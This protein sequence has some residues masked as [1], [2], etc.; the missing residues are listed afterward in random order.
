MDKLLDYYQA[1][2]GIFSQKGAKLVASLMATTS[3]MDPLEAFLIPRLE[4]VLSCRPRE[5]ILGTEW[6]GSI[7]IREQPAQAPQHRFTVTVQRTYYL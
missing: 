3:V 5:E 7:Q 2:P 1:M 4:A 6:H